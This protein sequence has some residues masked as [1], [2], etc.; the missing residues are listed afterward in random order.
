MNWLK[1]SLL[2][3]VGAWLIRLL[4]MAVRIRTEGADA[5]DDLYRQGGRIIIAFWH[6]RGLM[7]PG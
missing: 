6:G 7:M 3:P 4:G 2:P 5:V 1:M